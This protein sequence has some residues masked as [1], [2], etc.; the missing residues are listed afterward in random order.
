MGDLS[1]TESNLRTAI[2]D[3][4]VQARSRGEYIDALAKTHGLL[5][6]AF[7]M[8]LNLRTWDE[9]QSIPFRVK[10]E[11][12]SLAIAEKHNLR[13]I[14]QDRNDIVHKGHTVSDN[15]VKATAGRLVRFS[16]D[17]WSDIFGS[18]TVPPSLTR[19]ESGV[20]DETPPPTPPPP[21]PTPPGK[22]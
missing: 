17:A 13:Q 19:P 8:L 2:E 6:E 22:F 14:A 18:G 10:G 1:R 4:Y 20:L 3:T 16:V 11:R 9:Q 21:P 12:I 15:T 5:E 7:N